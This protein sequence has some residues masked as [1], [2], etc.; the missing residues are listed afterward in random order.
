MDAFICYALIA[1]ESCTGLTV[2]VVEFFFAFVFNSGKSNGKIVANTY[3]ELPYCVLEGALTVVTVYTLRRATHLL[4]RHGCR[5][6][7][8][9]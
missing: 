9:L 2:I 8:L 1:I 7:I 4:L 5:L 6:R 3:K